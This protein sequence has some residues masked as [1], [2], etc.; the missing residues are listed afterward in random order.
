MG[1]SCS[2]SS[3]SSS[4]DAIAE[5]SFFF[6][7]CH[8]CSTWLSA[9]HA[10]VERGHERSRPADEQ[11]WAESWGSPRH[12]AL[13][14]Y[15]S[16]QGAGWRRVSRL[17][18]D[19]VPCLLEVTATDERTHGV[20]SATQRPH[21]RQIEVREDCLLHLGR[22]VLQH[23]SLRHRRVRRV[24]GG[25]RESGWRE[26][27]RRQGALGGLNQ[28]TPRPRRAEQWGVCANARCFISTAVAEGC[29]RTFS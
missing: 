4:T 12:A 26:Q 27:R 10:C 1:T 21:A 13:A 24:R 9:C 29:C 17:A 22:K 25:W 11:R 28:Q 3:S 5:T 6:C 20:R 19:R 16:L 23:L 14:M 2:V 7:T 8:W 18:P 15:A